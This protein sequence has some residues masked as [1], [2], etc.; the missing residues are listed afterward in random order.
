MGIAIDEDLV[1]YFE[2]FTKTDYNNKMILTNVAALLIEFMIKS[3]PIIR[4]QDYVNLLFKLCTEFKPEQLSRVEFF[5]Q[6][7]LQY[8]LPNIPLLKS[9][10]LSHSTALIYRLSNQNEEAFAIWKE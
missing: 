2:K 10:N 9:F 1:D 3:K 4:N 8:C 5:N 6:L 7:P